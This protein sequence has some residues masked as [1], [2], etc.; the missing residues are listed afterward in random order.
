MPERLNPRCSWPGDRGGRCPNERSSQ[1]PSLLPLRRLQLVPTMADSPVTDLFLELTPE[2]VLAAVEVQAAMAGLVRAGK[3]RYDLV[4]RLP[5]GK[6]DVYY[7]VTEDG[8]HG[9]WAQLVGLE[10]DD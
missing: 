3:V 10:A 7:G 6:I 4:Q 1:E 9:V 5:D 8:I 2:R